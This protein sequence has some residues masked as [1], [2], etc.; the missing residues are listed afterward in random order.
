[1]TTL[2]TSDFLFR[3]IERFADWVKFADAKAAALVVVFGLGLTD[4]LAHAARLEEGHGIGG[5][6]GWAATVLFWVA[7][8][9]AA[10]TV[11]DLA[12]TLFPSLKPAQVSLFY[13]GT[14]AELERDE[15]A[16]R[17]SSL[18]SSALQ[19]DLSSQAWQLA[20][21]AQTKLARLRTAFYVTLCF[22]G[23]WALARIFLSLAG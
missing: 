23:A 14:V 1:M 8:V 5:F 4:L 16:N 13:F 3:S 11:L 10:W 12:R 17:I 18:T 15:Y 7:C 22:L 9:L 20:V 6:D 19:R 21:I 2:G